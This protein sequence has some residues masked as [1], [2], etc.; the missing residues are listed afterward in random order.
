MVF[1]KTQDYSQNPSFQHI[2]VHQSVRTHQAKGAA[3]W[4]NIQHRAHRWPQ[5]NFLFV[6][7]LCV[8]ACVCACVC[9]CVCA[10][11]L[12]FSAIQRRQRNVSHAVTH[13]SQCLGWI[14]RTWWGFRKWCF[15]TER[16][17]HK[18]FKR[19]WFEMLEKQDLNLNL[20]NLSV[21]VDLIARVRYSKSLS[22]SR[23][24]WD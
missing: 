4:T 1:C 19:F 21:S 18:Q 12:S 9:V 14:T 22:P 13:Q 24:W 3:K 20:N 6:T 2:E 15:H 16:W 7:S 5:S 17:A 23:T 10:C 8:C 11:V